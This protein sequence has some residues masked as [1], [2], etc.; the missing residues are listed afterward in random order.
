MQFDYEA[1]EKKRQEQTELWKGKLIG[2]KF[3]EDESLV[4]SI[5]ENEF[6]ANQLPQ[7]R[8]IL[9]GENVPMTM[10]FRPDRINVRLDKGG[11]CQDV[12]FV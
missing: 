5:G 9:K 4:S 8:R 12:F 6:T 10:D 3:I 1:M 11:I 7:S 2:K